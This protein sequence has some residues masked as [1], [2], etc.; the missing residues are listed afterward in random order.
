MTVR[1]LQC[2]L[3]IETLR[4]SLQDR[5]YVFTK[6]GEKL[7]EIERKII[8]SLSDVEKKSW[9]TEDL[10]EIKDKDFYIALLLTYWKNTRTLTP[11]DLKFVNNCL[12]RELDLNY[13]LLD[14]KNIIDSFHPYLIHKQLHFRLDKEVKSLISRYGGHDGSDVL[15]INTDF[16]NESVKI[17]SEKSNF[18]INK[19]I[20]D[21][22][23]FPDKVFEYEQFDFSQ[24]ANR[25]STII[26]EVPR[27]H[28]QDEH[29]FISNLISNSSS[30]VILIDSKQLLAKEDFYD[31][32]KKIIDENLLRIYIGGMFCSDVYILDTSHLNDKKQFHFV[33][34]H[35]HSYSIYDNFLTLH[36]KLSKADVQSINYNFN[37]ASDLLPGREGHGYSL[38][39]LFSI[40]QTGVEKVKEEGIFPVFQMKD[41]PCGIVDS[42]KSFSDLEQCEIS[43]SFKKVTENKIVF[44]VGDENIKTCYIEASNE[45]PIY[46]GNQ[47]AILNLDTTILMPQYVQLLSLRGS[48][49]EAFDASAYSRDFY[50][51]TDG[52][53]FPEVHDIYYFTPEKKILDINSLIQIPPISTQEKE[54]I[55]ARFINAPALTRER[56]LESMLA[57][58]TWLNKEH[59]RNIKHRLGNELTPIMM[60]ITALHKLFLNHPEGLFLDTL[61]G[62]NEKVSEILDRLSRCVHQ[63]NESIQ[64]LTRTVDKANL[65]PIDI[66]E[67]VSDYAKNIAENSLFTLNLNLPDRH[68]N[69]MGSVV[70]INS[71]LENIIDNARRHGFVDKNRDNYAIEI[72]ITEDG[73]GNCILSVKNN[74]SPM[75]EHA[76]EIYFRRGSIAGFTG[77][78]GIGGADVKD[79]ANAM[80]G[81]ATLSQEENWPVCVNISLPIINSEKI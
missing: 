17:M 67:A 3:Y 75:T 33:C 40:P 30:T 22:K 50:R 54:L 23:D 74:G 62:K 41:F 4:E 27:S 37:L 60:D 71:I 80:G 43:G 1:D 56:V 59:I 61:R 8:E 45:H 35:Q 24:I 57:E 79:T 34:K 26:A 28:E 18:L 73:S 2:K 64:D 11:S 58:N 48:F 10:E 72:S 21:L 16:F 20:H 65:K 12:I 29:S 66:V 6:Q 53:Y 52:A 5:D 68:I 42:I 78:S 39:E 47:F 7:L 81:E 44:F 63:V 15:E 9:G 77:H 70:M 69:V 38:K 14:N 76:R 32:R 31:F 25:Y 55:D 19:I 46:V 36:S 49:E 51:Y 13:D